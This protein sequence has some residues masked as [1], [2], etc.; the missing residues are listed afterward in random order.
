MLLERC[1]VVPRPTIFLV[2]TP[3][4]V[5]PPPRHTKSKAV[6]HS[7]AVKAA[8]ISSPALLWDV[9]GARQ[10]QGVPPTFSVRAARSWILSSWERYANPLQVVKGRDTINSTSVVR[11]EHV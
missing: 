9:S 7:E 2:T 11:M 4:V 5:Y 10:E 3:A 8:L 1:P 6:S